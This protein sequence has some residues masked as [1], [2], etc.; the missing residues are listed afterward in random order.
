V[1]IFP[2]KTQ[3]CKEEQFR[4]KKEG[5][6]IARIWHGVTAASNADRYLDYL[7]QTGLP[8]Y[9]R[10]AGNMGAYV[11]RKI[12]D[13]KAHFFTLSFWDSFESIKRFAGKNY[14]KAKYYPEDAGFLL[15]LEPNVRHYEMFGQPSTPGYVKKYVASRMLPRWW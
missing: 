3:S 8:D 5:K 6:M 11:L 2:A 9:R 14:D 15:E 1:G 10:T 13:G 12:E 7:N 4:N